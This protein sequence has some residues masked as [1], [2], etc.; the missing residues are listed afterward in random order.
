MR[1]RECLDCSIRF[2][3]PKHAVGRPALR[4][5]EC[6]RLIQI[7]RNSITKARRFAKDPEVF[8][9]ERRAA[10][11]RV[12]RCLYEGCPNP[13]IT[14]DGLCRSH[15]LHRLKTGSLDGLKQRSKRGCITFEGYVTLTKNGLRLREHRVVMEQHLGRSLESWENVHH[16]NGIKH[17][18]RLDNLE[19][20]VVSQPKGQRPEDLATWVVEHYPE[21]VR[22]A[23]TDVTT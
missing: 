16:K 10:A 12:A 19:L 5:T 13:K 21:I 15:Y 11:A 4:C 14:A 3:W 17:D 18:N 20:W 9:R 6:S 7:K 2:E 8:N 22:Q 23:L 1:Y